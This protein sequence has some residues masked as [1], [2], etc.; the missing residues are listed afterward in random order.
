MKKICNLVLA[1]LIIGLSSCDKVKDSIKANVP[2]TLDQIEFDLPP[3]MGE[4]EFSE[5]ITTHLNIDSLLKDANSSLSV[6]NI[7]SAKVE[8]LTL[9][10]DESTRFE[11]DN[12]TAMSLLKTYLS[13][14][15][16][17]SSIEI[18][19][20]INPTSEFEVAMQTDKDQDVKAYIVDNAIS[21]RIYGKLKRNTTNI[22]RCRAIVKLKI[23]AGLD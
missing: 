11:S 17:P 19:K 15:S 22:L 1:L 8:S 20:A 4:D 18:A 21:F 14:S 10:I 3:S 23:T 2:V 16:N 9:I 12:F 13:S 7:K 6:N 5:T